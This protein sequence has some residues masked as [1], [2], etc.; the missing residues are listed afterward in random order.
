M[1]QLAAVVPNER[2]ESLDFLR[3][4]ALLG[5]LAMNIRAMSARTDSRCDA[6]HQP[7]AI[8]RRVELTP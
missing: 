7:Q 6:D 1:P 3:G 5:I 2:L 4:F 8:G